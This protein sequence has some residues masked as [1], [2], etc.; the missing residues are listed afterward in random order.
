MSL[1]KAKGI[2]LKTTKLGEAD[3][4][5]TILTASRGKV[6]A[7]AKGIRKTKSKFGSR[8]E[9]FSHADMLLYAGRNGLDIVTQTELIQSF[10]EIRD[11]F[12][13]LAFG[14][15]MLDLAE[16]VSVEGDP[17]VALFNLL[18]KG[19][20]ATAWSKRNHRLLL[21]AFDLKLMS[22]T[23]YL[24]KLD[25][26][27]VCGNSAV[28]LK[29]FSNERGGAVCERCFDEAG[30][31]VPVRSAVLALMHELLRTK[32]IVVAEMDTV[33]KD[34]AEASRV[35]SDY[36]AYHLQTRLRSRECLTQLGSLT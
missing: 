3:K 19:L 33:A 36:V 13:R 17:D 10:S 24:P 2:V 14:S 6:R 22:I 35:V 21:T 32:L 16:K 27:T 25:A 18:A 12:D 4:I 11:D 15:G 30:F 26:C 5:I 28:E 23:G 31:G 20:E 8:L 9:P 34:E 1:Y 7:V 29:R